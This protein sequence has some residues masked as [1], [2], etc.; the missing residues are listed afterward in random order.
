MS[1]FTQESFIAILDV[2]YRELENDTGLDIDSETIENAIQEV[3][4]IGV[5]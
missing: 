3:T 5:Y 4:T 1:K 2:L